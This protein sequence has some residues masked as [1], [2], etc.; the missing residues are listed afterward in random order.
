MLLV[1]VFV[2]APAWSQ[3]QT[4]IEGRWE[5]TL[6]QDSTKLRLV[7]DVTRASD[8]LLLGMIANL[9]HG[10]RIPIDRIDESGN[11]V[12]LAV[13]AIGASYDGALSSDGRI[14]GSWTQGAPPT[15]LEFRRAATEPARAET[16]PAESGDPFGLSVEMKV[17]VPPT[18]FRGDGRTHLAYELH[19]TNFADGELL[20]RKLEIL[21]GDSAIASF[22]GTQLN[23]MLQRPG[24]P[25]VIDKRAVGAGQRAIA[26]LWLSAG[27]DLRMPPSLRH[28][29][30]GRTESV[31]GGLVP[32]SQTPP[33][34]LG[35]PLRGSNWVAVNGPD[36]SSGHRRALLPFSGN[37]TIGQRF[38]I[39]WL[40]SG[41][42]GRTFDGDPKDNK[43]YRAYGEELLA[44]GDG[45]IVFVQDGIPENVPGP[46]SRA[47]SIG[48]G[49]IAGNVVVIDLGSQRF[50]FYGH[51]QRGSLRVKVGDKV[52]RGQVLGLIGNSGNSDEPHLHFHVTNSA[53]MLESEGLPY[54]IDSFETLTPPSAW[55]RRSNELPLRDAIVR[56]PESK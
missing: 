46:G 1:M 9:D 53:S 2:D 19:I 30:T 5:G 51:V 12:R 15:A 44:V 43:S 52:R 24:A 41:P 48:P 13:N 32:I 4:G 20:I 7:L 27:G 56:F 31:E 47:V 11:R 49:T 16:K 42:D 28:R 54:V 38:A 35:P 6:T 36:N 40:Q 55:Q 14:T 18:P 17:P 22:E 23:S 29:I 33:I 26:Y 37:T 50:A 21:A 8:G 3:A 45:V 10:V 25:N 34:V 39:D